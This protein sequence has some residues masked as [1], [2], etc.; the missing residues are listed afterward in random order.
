MKLKIKKISIYILVL[1]SLTGFWILD[2]YKIFIMLNKM[3]KIK[4]FILCSVSEFL[5]YYGTFISN[6]LFILAFIII[7]NNSYFK[8]SSQRIIRYGKRKKSYNIRF[9]QIIVSS[10][11]FGII[12]LIVSIVCYSTLV[13]KD[14][15]LSFNLYW[16]IFFHFFGVVIHYAIVGC[17]FNIIKDIFKSQSVAILI[18]ILIFFGFSALYIERCWDRF[19][20]I[21]NVPLTFDATLYTF[22]DLLVGVRSIQHLMFSYLF[23]I[24]GLIVL[25]FLGAFVYERKDFIKAK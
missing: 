11:S 6:S 12:H 10:I 24:C 4:E 16:K 9:K 14:I 25:Y 3:G 1:L 23:N 19:F 7:L 15:L 5:G 8:M 18:T 20:I 21:Q 22:T 2:H 13:N 17:I